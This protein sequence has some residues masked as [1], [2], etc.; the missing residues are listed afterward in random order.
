MSLVAVDMKKDPDLGE[1]IKAEVL[2]GSV[3]PNIP[4][5]APV[6]PLGEVKGYQ[7]LK[8]HPDLEGYVDL[9]ATEYGNFMG[10]VDLVDGDLEGEPVRLKEGTHAIGVLE[11][12]RWLPGGQWVHV[13]LRYLE[14]PR[15]LL[16]VAIPDKCE[17]LRYEE[18][19]KG[20]VVLIRCIVLGDRVDRLTGKR[21]P[22]RRYRI[23][24]FR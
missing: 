5:G 7:E 21:Y 6:A 19:L 10:F 9:M 1:T 13:Y 22:V 20:K 18:A 12:I 2:E 15:F 14:D 3:C 23:R 8:D 11:R 4:A 24:P 16:P 17:D